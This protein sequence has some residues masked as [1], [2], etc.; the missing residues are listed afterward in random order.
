MRYS[1]TTHIVALLLA[2]LGFASGLTFFVTLSFWL[3]DA[4]SSFARE[5]ELALALFA[6][7][8]FYRSLEIG[9]RGDYLQGFMQQALA[10]A[11]AVYGCA[12]G[13]DGT[14][15]CF[16]DQA[17]A[18]V[19]DLGSFLGEAQPGIVVRRLC[20]RQWVGIV[21]GKR[22]LDLALQLQGA[23]LVARPMAFRFAMEPWY[24]NILAFQRY[25]AVYLLINLIILSVVGFFRMREI[26]L[27]PVERLLHLTN[28]Y[29]DEHGVPFLAL[30]NANELA[31]LYTAMQQM[32]NRIRTDREKLQQHVSS[33]EQA[34]LQ[35]RNTREEMIRT[36][37]L[38]SVGRLAAGLAHEIGNPV[39][40]VQGYLG[41]LGRSD[42]GDNE[43]NE[44]C[45]RAEQELQRV[46]QL[47]RRLL[48][49]ARPSSG[50]EEQVDPH[51][52]IEEA[53]ALLCPQPLFDGIEITCALCEQS[54]HVRCDS[55]QLL[56][57]LLN[58]LMNAA[59]AIHTA[60][61]MPGR[62]R[63]SSVWHEQD[64]RQFI[65]ILIADNGCGMEE[66]ELA[67]AFDPFFTTKAPGQGT[68]LGLSVSYSLV[69]A[70]GGAI[71]LANQAEGGAVVTIELPL[72]LDAGENDDDWSQS[73]G[74]DGSN[75]FGFS[76]L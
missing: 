24:G 20:G 36:E 63:I 41:L 3:R 31:Q 13:D 70:M 7:R 19:A 51:L 30:Q 15:V 74:K 50:K 1:L 62:I 76:G 8:Q 53:L 39:G 52:A 17:A 60:G 47:I 71:S 26:I 6:E 21:P 18:G 34:N 42:V 54:A 12:K 67:A 10:S 33:L 40:I 27:R 25:I 56:Q 23:D 58:C 45:R 61:C 48:D 4:G 69:Q 38:S 43:R 14:P 29:R 22:Y 66:H 37:K 28:S 55:G 35:L 32:L 44:F 9:Y 64:N 59:D 16:G 49:F 5:K 65:R 72:S 11:G 2:V 46:N 75:G 73:R 68:G 57:V